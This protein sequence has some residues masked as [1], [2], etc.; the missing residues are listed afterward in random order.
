MNGRRRR[1]I[2]TQKNNV[3]TCFFV[4]HRRHLG[5]FSWLPCYISFFFSLRSDS[6]LLL[7]I[8][9]NNRKRDPYV[10]QQKEYRCTF[11]VLRINSGDYTLRNIRVLSRHV[12]IRNTCTVQVRL[13]TL[14]LLQISSTTVKKSELR[15]WNRGM[16]QCLEKWISWRSAFPGGQIDHCTAE[17]YTYLDPN[18]VEEEEEKLGKWEAAARRVN[19]TGI[20]DH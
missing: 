14:N 6:L 5:L 20:S 1:S 17:L 8:T 3:S 18:Q 11:V 4:L 9:A 16:A 10:W 15:L 13:V 19:M 7:Q 12:S 2:I